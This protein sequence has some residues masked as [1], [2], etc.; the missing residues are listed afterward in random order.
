MDQSNGYEKVALAFVKIRGNQSNNI[1]VSTVRNWAS[2][3]PTSATVLD[4]GC[5]PGIPISKTLMDQ[6]LTV[7]GIDAS[8]TLVAQFKENF[9][10]H[11]IRCEAVE[12]SSF[13]GMAFDAVIA[14]GLLFLLSPEK[15]RALIGKIAIHLKSGG[16]FLFTAPSQQVKWNDV[17]TGLPSVSLGAEAYRQILAE[18]G[19]LVLDEYQDEGENYYYSS[20]KK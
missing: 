15:Q 17:M 4:L 8:P 1:G 3:L 11:T 2:A 6:Q 7:Y 13:F 16:K 5:G 12:T 10:N 14:W 18:N 19:F 9:P 20:M